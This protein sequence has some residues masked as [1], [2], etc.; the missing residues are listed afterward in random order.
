MSNETLRIVYASWPDDDDLV[1]EITTQEA[2]VGEVRRRGSGLFLHLSGEVPS[3]VPLGDL[4]L[5]IAEIRQ[6]LGS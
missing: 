1:A 2:Y 3:P 5:A 6:R 4:E